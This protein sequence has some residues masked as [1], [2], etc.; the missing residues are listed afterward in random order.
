MPFLHMIAGPNG[1][2][3]STLHE[4]LVAPRYPD[5]PFARTEHERERLHA[6]RQSYVCESVFSRPA[7]LAFVTR[8]KSEGF[9]VV[10]YIVCLD[11]PLKLLMRVRGSKAPA[12]E[13]DMLG[14]KILERYPRTLKNLQLAVRVAD[15]SLLINSADPHEGGPELVASVTAGHMH[16]RTSTRPQWADKVLGFV[17]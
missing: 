5:L 4:F 17:E 16:L 7:E 6:A 10:L 2:G 1:A 14:D 13:P 8:A 11:D 3:K 12:G 15:L 9:H